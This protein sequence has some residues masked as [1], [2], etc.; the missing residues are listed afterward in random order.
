MATYYL[1]TLLM[2]FK[3]QHELGFEA[4]ELILGIIDDDEFSDEDKEDI[5]LHTLRKYGL[6]ET[7]MKDGQF[8]PTEERATVTS[9]PKKFVLVTQYHTC[10]IA[11]PMTLNLLNGKFPVEICLN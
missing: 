10:Y 4:I 1:N 11:E 7:T 3:S 2:F 5:I 6:N 8:E 9:D